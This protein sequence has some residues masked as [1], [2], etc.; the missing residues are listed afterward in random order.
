MSQPIRTR[1]RERALGITL[2]GSFHCALM[3][4]RTHADLQRADGSARRADI[5]PSVPELMRAN[6]V[7]GSQDFQL[8]PPYSLYL[9]SQRL[10]NRNPPPPP[11]LTNTHIHTHKTNIFRGIWSGFSGVVF[12]C[13]DCSS[14]IVGKINQ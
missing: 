10:K 11:T 12:R 5:C 9:S 14:T 4:S 7:M 6:A 3:R 13:A 2:M 1:A 8:E